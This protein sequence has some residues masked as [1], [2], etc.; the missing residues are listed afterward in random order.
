MPAGSRQLVPGWLINPLVAFPV[1]WHAGAV[2]S[3][4]LVTS[5]DEDERLSPV[6]VLLAG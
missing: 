1:R 2:G 5:T 3:Y 4:T 6:H